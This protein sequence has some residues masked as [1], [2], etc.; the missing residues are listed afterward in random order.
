M[1]RNAISITTFL[2]AI[3]LAAIWAASFSKVQYAHNDLGGG[4]NSAT[5]FA[6]RGTLLFEWKSPA[7]N[8]TDYGLLGHLP[9]ASTLPGVFEW[10]KPGLEIEVIIVGS[11]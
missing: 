2:V 4:A 11:A 8:N 6:H 5:F 9:N 3:F 7:K 1:I 10:S